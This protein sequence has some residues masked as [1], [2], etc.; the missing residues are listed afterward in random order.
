MVK[1]NFSNYG[2]LSIHK[3]LLIHK[4]IFGF[5]S[6]FVYMEGF[7]WNFPY[8]HFWV[9]IDCLDLNFPV[10]IMILLASMLCL[11]NWVCIIQ[12]K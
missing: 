4:I 3:L 11:F 5:H 9:L 6:P 7:I 8:N 10:R 1:F 12:S 2:K